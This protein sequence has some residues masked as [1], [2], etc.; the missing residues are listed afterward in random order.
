MKQVKLEFKKDPCIDD[1]I[2]ETFLKIGSVNIEELIE[3]SKEKIDFNDNT[4]YF[5]ELE[6]QYQIH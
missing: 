4:H 3:N 2:S 1:I 6:I 5:G